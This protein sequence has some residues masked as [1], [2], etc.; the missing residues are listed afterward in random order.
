MSSTSGDKQTFPI[1]LLDQILQQAQ[2]QAQQPQEQQAQHPIDN[3]LNTHSAQQLQQ[4]QNL[5]EIPAI[6][7]AVLQPNQQLSVTDINYQ[8]FQDTG[9][10][11][12]NDIGNEA[13]NQTTNIGI[14]PQVD[15]QVQFCPPEVPAMNINKAAVADSL[16]TNRKRTRGNAKSDDSDVSDTTKTVD[17]LAD[18]IKHARVEPGTV[19]TASST[20]TTTTVMLTD[21]HDDD[22]SDL[23]FV[24]SILPDLSTLSLQQKR[25]FKVGLLELIEKITRSPPEDN[26]NECIRVQ[27]KNPRKS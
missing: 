8:A 24:R 23:H 17:H 16:Q 21:G 1:V 5:Q 12:E 25:R 15:A 14:L 2:M 6:I 19:R 7:L 22:Q 3:S 11:I 18:M 20:T 4:L 9:A 27:L 26:T 10:E 13:L